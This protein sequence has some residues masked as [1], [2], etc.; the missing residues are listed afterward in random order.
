MIGPSVLT[1]SDS[2]HQKS[3]MSSNSLLKTHMHASHRLTASRTDSAASMV[4]IYR[5]GL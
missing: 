5:A 2:V 1:L 3:D 4:E